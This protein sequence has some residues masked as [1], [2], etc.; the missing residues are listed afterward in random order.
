MSSPEGWKS[1][2]AI[3]VVRCS[4]DLMGSG[5]I[6]GMEFGSW[7]FEREEVRVEVSYRLMIPVDEL[8]G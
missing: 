8:L 2:V 4:S 7:D 1:I 6:V 5:L 3:D